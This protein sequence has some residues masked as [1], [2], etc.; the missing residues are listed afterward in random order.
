MK[1]KVKRI[2]FGSLVTVGVGG[3]ALTMGWGGSYYN[4]DGSFRQI[5]KF[6]SF[7]HCMN[8]PALEGFGEYVMPWETGVVTKVVKPLNLN[9][10]TKCLGY[11][12]DGVVNGINF[13]IDMA[14]EDNLEVLDIY[15]QEQKNTDKSKESTKIIYIQGNEGAPLAIVLAG[16]GF[17]S[18]C[19]MQEAFP[20]AKILHEEGYN[21]IMLKYRVGVNEGEKRFVEPIERAMEDLGATVS[22]IDKNANTLGLK[23]DNYST[24]GFS[25]GGMLTTLWGL[26]SNVG[27]QSLDLP[28]PVMNVNA[29]ASLYFTEN[30][31]D[32]RYKTSPE[33][34]V[35][36]GGSDSVIKD[37]GI[38]WS[39]EFSNYLTKLGISSKYNE[40][41]GMN[42]GFGSGVGT[43]AEEWMDDAI[44]FWKEAC[45][46]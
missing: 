41:E 9:Y 2:I 20:V 5:S 8:H 44:A 35:V 19:M 6:S 12:T 10:M 46:K 27:Y 31:F 42:H 14:N 24:W 32:D 7:S 30:P 3:L 17:T 16:G 1:K 33:T 45:N 38:K 40:I 23:L 26:D 37:V 25:A 39:Q 21:V 13:L 36:V 4:K 43:N 11:D 22:Y 29:Y 15:T 34:Y 18:V 28:K